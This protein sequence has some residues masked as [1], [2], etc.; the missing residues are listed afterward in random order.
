MHSGTLGIASV[1]IVVALLLFGDFACATQAEYRLLNQQVANLE[2]QQERSLEEQKEA[3][4]EI[5][6]NLEALQSQLADLLARVQVLE[7]N[8]QALQGQGFRREEE[9][10]QLLNRI[11]LL[12]SQLSQLEQRII[13]LQTPR[14]DTRN[15]S[16]LKESRLDEDGLY[17][18]ALSSFEGGDYSRAQQLLET[19]KQRF[20]QGKYWL[21]SEFWLGEIEYRQKNYPQ[22]I[23][24]YLEVIEKGPK[25]PKAPAAY[26]KMAMALKELQESEK[27]RRA[28][29]DL[30]RLY[31]HSA[32]AE[33]AKKLL[34]RW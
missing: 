5:R 12:E 15:E 18:Q 8:Q 24:H 25:H 26:L 23:A 14:G 28:L 6:K 13:T 31:P 34:K 19:L 1:L 30:V 22:A 29:E 3:L 17:A 27:A 20:P 11:A 16:F 21:N 7:V 9:K 33:E 10:G 32:Q 4:T 2:K